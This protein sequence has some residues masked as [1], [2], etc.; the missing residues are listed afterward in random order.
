MT[1]QVEFLQYILEL[2]N[3]NK[4]VGKLRGAINA[5]IERL[6]E[7][8]P[9]KG[10]RKKKAPEVEEDPP[11]DEVDPYGDELDEEDYIEPPRESS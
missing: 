2:I 5:E 1:Q 3:S 6:E 9:A 11:E 8:K 7:P 10:S 4:P